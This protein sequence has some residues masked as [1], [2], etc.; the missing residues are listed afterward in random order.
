MGIF[1]SVEVEV[2]NYDIAQYIACD[3]DCEEFCNIINVIGEEAD[4]LKMLL[5]NLE[6]DDFTTSGL[7]AVKMIAQKFNE[8]LEEEG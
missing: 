6:K 2:T 4:D 1:K 3:I 5:K 8:I 7:K